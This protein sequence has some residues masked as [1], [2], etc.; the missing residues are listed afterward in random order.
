MPLLR[1][2]TVAKAGNADA[3]NED[4]YLC[5]PGERDGEFLL[6]VADGATDSLF[7]GI[8]ARLLVEEFPTI[9]AS[10]ASRARRSKAFRRWIDGLQASWLEEVS[11]KPLPWYA[12]HK[13]TTGAH[14]ALVGIRVC[15][16][17]TEL[18][19]EAIAVG[20]CNLF[21]VENDELRVG[22]PIQKAEDF[23]VT[24][25]LIG[26]TQAAN[27]RLLDFLVFDSGSAGASA[28]FF[29][30]SDA[31][32]Q[33]FL[34]ANERNQCPWRALRK[35]SCDVQFRRFVNRLRSRQWIRNDDTT[36]IML[37]T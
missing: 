4:A 29:V 26:T 9:M 32:A 6:A 17:E 21:V 27:A 35:L 33:W 2:F 5:H 15:S 20:D 7:S 1:S 16:S 24:P 19:W 30:M 36:L 25:F 3:E 28:E 37:G 23:G 22:M 8:W 11:N 13:L 34:A 14:A 12:E 31:L 18:R 10:R